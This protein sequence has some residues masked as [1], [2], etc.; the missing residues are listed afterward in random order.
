MLVVL[1][2]ATSLTQQNQTANDLY[3]GDVAVGNLTETQVRT[4]LESPEAS[5]SIDDVSIQV[6]ADDAHVFTAAQLGI[7]LDVRATTAAA[8][9]WVTG[10]SATT[11]V[12]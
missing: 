11:M 1:W 5:P 2:I 4:R 10:N 6:G 7:E 9:C 8:M 3:V 12:M